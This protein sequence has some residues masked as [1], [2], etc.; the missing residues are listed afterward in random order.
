MHVFVYNARMYY[1]IHIIYKYTHYTYMY[2]GL[3][4]PAAVYDILHLRLTVDLHVVPFVNLRPKQMAI[5]KSIHNSE[6]PSLNSYL[7]NVLIMG[8]MKTTL[9]TMVKMALFSTETVPR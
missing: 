6:L 9:M 8:L 1:C 7:A 4:W 2:I 3:T 5:R